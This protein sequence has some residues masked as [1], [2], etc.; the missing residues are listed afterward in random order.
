MSFMNLSR[1]DGSVQTRIYIF[2]ASV[3]VIPFKN[4]AP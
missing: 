1:E 3:I 2:F 4:T